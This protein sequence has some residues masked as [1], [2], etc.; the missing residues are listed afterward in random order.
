[1]NWPVIKSTLRDSA[2]VHSGSDSDDEGIFLLPVG[3]PGDDEVEA[4]SVAADVGDL[5]GPGVAWPGQLDDRSVH[6]FLIIRTQSVRSGQS[7]TIGEIHE[8]LIMP[9]S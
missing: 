9:R 8:I 2:E 7:L 5:C 6:T 3:V 4:V 1:M